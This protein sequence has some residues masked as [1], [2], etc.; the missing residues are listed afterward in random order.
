L[1]KGGHNSSAWV[2]NF[3]LNSLT[4]GNGACVDVVDQN[5]TPSGWTSGSEVL[6]LDAPY[7]VTPGTGITIP[8]LNLV[9]IETFLLGDGFLYN[10]LY[11]N[12]LNGT[13]VMVIG[14]SLV[15]EPAAVLLLGAGLAFTG[16]H[17][18]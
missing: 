8:T 17:R 3:A 16:R 14:A 5:A 4:L 15:P 10:G 18:S 1:N 12:P 7:G 6:Y 9:G 11:T 13:E 2:Q